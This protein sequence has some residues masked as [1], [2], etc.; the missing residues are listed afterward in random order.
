MKPG[1][2]QSQDLDLTEL[3]IMKLCHLNGQKY[4][5][6][7]ILFLSSQNLH[8]AESESQTNTYIEKM[9]ILYLFI[10]ES[11]KGQSLYHLTLDTE[12]KY[13]CEKGTF[14][15]FHQA[16]FSKIKHVFYACFTINYSL[17]FQFI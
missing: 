5:I 7:Y 12:Q 17:M 4:L 11:G 13:T 14:L 15:P 9:C 6:S 10:L 2:G 16:M 3:I 1:E 8:E